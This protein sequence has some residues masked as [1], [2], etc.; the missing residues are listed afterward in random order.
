MK[1][2][3]NHAVFGFIIAAAA[4]AACAQNPDRTPNAAGGSAYLV[5]SRG[6][7]VRSQSGLC[8]HSGSWTP[9]DA[10]IGCDGRL[11][12]PIAKPTAPPIAAPAAARMAAATPAAPPPKRC[13]FAVTL[14]GDQSFAF[15]RATLAEAAKRHIDGEVLKRFAACGTIEAVFVTGHADRLGAQQYNQKLSEKRA[16]AVAAYL[17]SHRPTLAIETLG[18]GK[19]R[20][21][22]SCSN[23]LP[24]AKLIECLAPDRRVTIE[25]RGTS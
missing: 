2:M 5:D 19:T 7:V 17:R 21:V 6:A 23:K 1:P 3:L 25:V 20:P 15:N 14:N 4:S 10:M 13:D 9:A 8:W 11:V 12:P 22:A 16:A 24:R 18:V